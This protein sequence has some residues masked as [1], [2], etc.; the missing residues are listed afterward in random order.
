MPVSFREKFAPRE[1][2]VMNRLA[3]P[4]H[5]LSRKAV[6]APVE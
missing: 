4:V 6:S 1:E 2:R 5:L 3:A